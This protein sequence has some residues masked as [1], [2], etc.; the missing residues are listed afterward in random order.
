LL[1][2]NPASKIVIANIVRFI[3]EISGWEAR[4]V[5]PWFEEY[6]APMAEPVDVLPSNSS[7]RL[8]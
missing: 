8:F 7:L 5:F 2:A 4:N 1:T 6:K 3:M